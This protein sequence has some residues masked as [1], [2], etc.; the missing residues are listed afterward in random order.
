MKKSLFW[1]MTMLIAIALP[2]FTACGDDEEEPSLDELL[3]D[4]TTPVTFE[5]EKGTHF[6]YD[7]AGSHYVGGDTIKVWE[8]KEVKRDLRQ[9]RHS[10]LWLTDRYYDK[11]ELF[12]THYDANHK[13]LVRNEEHPTLNHPVG[14]AESEI[15]V[16]EYL[17]PTQT[18]TYSALISGL[19]LYIEDADRYP[20]VF[21][22]D[23]TQI[24]GSLKGYPN[25]VS[26]SLTGNDYERRESVDLPIYY[27]P[28]TSNMKIMGSGEFFLCPKEGLDDIQLVIEIKG[29][30]GKVITTSE[31]PKLSFRRGDYIHLRGTLFSG[32]A[33][34]WSV[35]EYH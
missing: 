11:P 26:V 32:S 23:K 2:L 30:D 18:L 25:I 24:I 7:Y 35:I 19:D 8:K 34:D 3:S 16:G 12:E 33:S 14:Y 22:N 29:T 10:I 20:E 17:L 9:G 21:D 1:S 4:K 6:M 27:Y 15:N 5:L 31:L 28:R 13:M